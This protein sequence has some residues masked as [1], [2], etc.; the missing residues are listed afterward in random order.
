MSEISSDSDSDLLSH[1]NH[2]QF[3]ENIQ[4]IE[5]DSQPVDKKAKKNRKK[6]SQKLSKLPKLRQILPAKTN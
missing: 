3:H 1:A 2:V 6:T 4:S 5:I